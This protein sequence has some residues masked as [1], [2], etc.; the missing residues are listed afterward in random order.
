V[1]V[2]GIVT[3]KMTDK[4]GFF[5]QHNASRWGGIFVNLDYCQYEDRS[6][7]NQH[8][9]G[10]TLTS[11]TLW[12][13]V[14][15]DLV[16]NTGDRVRV[17]GTVT[18]I[19]GTTSI[20][21]VSRVDV[22]GSARLPRPLNVTTGLINGSCSLEREPYE[23]VLVEVRDARFLKDEGYVTHIDVSDGTGALQGKTNAFPYTLAVLRSYY[24][25]TSLEGNVMSSVRGIVGY[26]TAP[27]TEEH[28]QYQ[29]LP[30][31]FGDLEGI[32]HAPTGVPSPAPSLVPTI[33][34]APSASSVPS[35]L[36]LPLPTPLPTPAPSV[37]SVPTPLPSPSPTPLPSHIPS[38][39][40][41]PNPSVAP[42]PLPTAIPSPL[43]RSTPTV[44]PTPLPTSAPTAQPTAVPTVMPTPLPTSAPTA[45]PTA[46]PSPVPSTRPSPLPSPIP[47]AVP[48]PLPSPIPTAVPTPVPTTVPS[49]MPT[50]A[51]T[52]APTLT[53]TTSQPSPLPSRIPTSAP[54]VDSG[55][56]VS[57]SS[58]FVL[59]DVSVSDLT[60]DDQTSIKTAIA[61]V[62]V[63]AA[64]DDIIIISITDASRRLR[65][66][67]GAKPQRLG[68]GRG[69]AS[70]SSVG[71]RWLLA[72]GVEVE[73]TTY[74]VLELTNFD[75]A[76]DLFD[77]VSGLVEDGAADGTLESE[78]QEEATSGSAL[79][80]ATLE[81]SSY[82]SDETYSEAIVDLGTISPTVSLVPSP[83][84]SVEPTA[85][86][87]PAPT[88][89]TA[90]DGGGGDSGGGGGGGDNLGAIAGGGAGGAL[91]LIGLAV[92][93][94][95]KRKQKELESL[96]QAGRSSTG[97]SHRKMGDDAFSK[98]LRR[99]GS[100]KGSGS[101][102][103]SSSPSSRVAAA[104]SSMKNIVNSPPKR[105]LDGITT[106]VLDSEGANPM[107]TLDAGVEMT[108]AGWGQ[109]GAAN[110]EMVQGM[111]GP[112]STKALV[113]VSA[114]VVLGDDGNASPN[115]MRRESSDMVGGGGRRRTSSSGGRRGSSDLESPGSGSG[116]SPFE[117]QHPSDFTANLPSR[118]I[119]KDKLGGGSGRA[120][121]AATLGKAIATDT[122]VQHSPTAGKVG[123]LSS[124][125][126]PTQ[127]G[128]TQ[129]KAKK[130]G[131]MERAKARA[132]ARKAGI[133]SAAVYKPKPIERTSSA[134][135]ESN[136]GY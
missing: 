12:K 28:Q 124:K 70:G 88:P 94:Y 85:A 125:P 65:G 104:W 66:E 32:T 86:T 40:P 55:T 16:A 92:V 45:Q 1:N 101:G 3:G 78:I 63:Y 36:P 17:M 68:S 61:S 39:L 31:D 129:K 33:T 114:S 80:T 113:P 52:S 118:R 59:A 64:V 60:E 135:G 57:W 74:L 123:E 90:T 89:T 126:D 19:N 75:N 26:C 8:V 6:C 20:A 120:G 102:S 49:P 21:S 93:I 35:P 103:N 108:D 91:L 2:S 24:G 22:I 58:S 73:Y 62:S 50:S 67:G 72:G 47:A 87:V 95:F 97:Q 121:P 15:F 25:I 127:P 81:A 79:E 119:P 133:E 38:P 106:T 56:L 132:A 115:P 82:S 96:K 7:I 122:A 27:C 100:S 76:D 43:P 29:L 46:V 34:S 130:M 110:E 42:S 128:A 111:H 23:S 51:P 84:P 109:D 9:D 131:L 71:R 30:R 99:S 136:G 13:S 134:E 98:S 4:S 48:T 83:K 117:G 14:S 54:T 107:A 18:E 53:P 116:S 105:G 10:T 112:S 37:S 77:T 44:M 41:S 69:G 5:M 11:R